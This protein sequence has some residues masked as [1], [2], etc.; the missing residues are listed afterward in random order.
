MVVLRSPSPGH[1]WVK[2]A[3]K[4]LHDFKIAFRVERGARAEILWNKISLQV[5]LTKQQLLSARGLT[6]AVNNGVNA[7]LWIAAILAPVRVRAF[8]KA[9]TAAVMKKR[10]VG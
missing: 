8:R 7:A 1:A 6:V 5:P 3:S 10:V 2:D 4:V 9:Q